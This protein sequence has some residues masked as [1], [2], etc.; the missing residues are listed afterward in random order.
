MTVRWLLVLILS[1]LPLVA[2]A[3]AS[4]PVDI[5]IVVSLDRSESID[6]DDAAA[7]I[8][9][10]VFALRHSRFRKSVGVGHFAAQV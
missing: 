6:A 5:A 9:G 3:E 7:Q 10:L 4:M 1:A 2:R 8:D